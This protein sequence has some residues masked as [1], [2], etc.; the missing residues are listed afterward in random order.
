MK[1]V[2]IVALLTLLSLVFTQRSVAPTQAAEALTNTPATP[3]AT[4]DWSITEIDDASSVM[5]LRPAIAINPLTQQP[6]VTHFDQTNS[7]LGVAARAANGQGNC[8]TNS[9]WICTVPDSNGAGYQSSIDFKANGDYAIAYSFSNKPQIN[10][11]E[12][13]GLNT[14]VDLINWPTSSGSL[15]Y[16]GVKFAADG[17]PR[18]TY[19]EYWPYTQE[20]GSVNRVIYNYPNPGFPGEWSN[21]Q[22]GHS[23]GNTD[24]ATTHGVNASL[25]I[26]LN[27]QA[28][29]AYRSRPQIGDASGLMYSEYRDSG[30]CEQHWDCLMVDPSNGSGN[31]I[32]LHMPQCSGCGDGTRI[33]YYNS[34]AEEVRFARYSGTVVHQCGAGGHDHW[35]C[36]K[37]DS[38]GGGEAMGVAMAHHNGT[39]YIA[40]YDN[41]DAA[42]PNGVL[43]LATYLGPDA[44]FGNCGSGDQAGYWSCEVVDDGGAAKHKVGQYT[45]M[46]IDAIGRIYIA[47]HDA[48]SGSLR[49][50]MKKMAPAPTFTR[51]FQPATIPVHG[52]SMV[53]YTIT[54][55]ASYRISGLN[56][57]NGLGA[58]NY[59]TID[60]TSL[61]TTCSGVTFTSNNIAIK[62]ANG[63]L[64]ANA[65]CTIDIRVTANVPGKLGPATTVLGS[66]EVFSAA[67]ADGYLTVL[68]GVYLPLISR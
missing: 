25:D 15:D 61:A 55:N 20:D 49:I 51:T 33:A 42:Y 3:N 63:T 19:H 53:H 14:T 67:G 24:S 27:N 57:V 59:L 39:P 35:Y 12:K 66:N 31:Y 9:G 47:Y 56:F 36:A 52:S 21:Y 40:Y 32:S 41:N 5:G 46:A 37:I 18:I 54:N 23:D 22:A 29:V 58:A 30:S 2:R 60:P 16:P 38:V 26:S 64:D 11:L 62:Q 43:K 6:L 8:G 17:T 1:L 34:V 48:T 10:L 50:A 44:L 4:G 68:Y 7:R 28:G 65:S 45:A 13:T